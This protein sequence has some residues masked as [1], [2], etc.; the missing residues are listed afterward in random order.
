[1]VVAESSEIQWPEGLTFLSN[2]I[3]GNELWQWSA[4]LAT[5]LAVTIVGP[6][7][8]RSIR[9]RL[10]TIE[11][12]GAADWRDAIIRML[13][14]TRSVVLG[15]L[16][17]TIGL[18]FLSLPDDVNSLLSR[19][20]SSLVII[21]VGL[22]V[23]A[24]LQGL[25]EVWLA[26][27]S[28]RMHTTAVVAVR[29]VVRMVVWTLVVLTILSNFGVQI[30]A[31]VA[32]LGI[33][34]VAAALAVQSLLGD[35]FS[36]LFLFA[37]RPFDIGDFIVL[38]E[39]VGT[40]Q[41]IGWRTT[42]IRAL[43]GQELIF[44]NNDLTSSRINNFGRMKDRRV[45]FE[46]GLV[47]GTATEDVKRVPSMIREIIEGSEGVRFDRS[48]F[49]GFGSSALLF[50]TVFFVF[51]PDYTEYMSRQQTIML[52]ILEKFRKEGLEF[53][54]PTQTIHLNPGDRGDGEA[55][56]STAS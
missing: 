32:G 54:F 34:G 55:E 46:I 27:S 1:M 44:P 14:A 17:L 13:S 8:L 50:E 36:A 29:L 21:Q 45:V 26:K 16:G 40:V 39:D 7:V 4:A 43:G 18:R 10:R 20:A 52:A 53:A 28:E 48:H 23:S 15:L 11:A 22:W 38:G 30:S 47:Y 9:Q 3:A 49:K 31:V 42:R 56:P 35:V 25:F 6:V 33:G 41:S 37:D 2:E 51:G 24:I 12:H 5:T 19:F